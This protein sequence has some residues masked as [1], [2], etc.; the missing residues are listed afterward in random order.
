MGQG[1]RDRRGSW[2]GSA[3]TVLGG[4]RQKLHGVQTRLPGDLLCD[5]GQVTGP[6]WSQFPPLKIKWSREV[7]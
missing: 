3:G 4:D 2:A 1:C 6:L 5:H 7:G